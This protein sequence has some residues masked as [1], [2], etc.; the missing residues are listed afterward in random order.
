[1][2]SATPRG[3]TPRVI[4]PNH[5]VDSVSWDDVADDDLRKGK[6]EE[7]LEEDSDDLDDLEDD[8][9][10]DLDDLEEDD[11]AEIEEEGEEIPSLFRL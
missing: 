7:V 11:G 3:F 5:R 10:E 1:M 6:N 9:F 8:D 2:I 4:H